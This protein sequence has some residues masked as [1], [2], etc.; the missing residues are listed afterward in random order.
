MMAATQ[1]PACSLVGKPNRTGRAPFGRAQDA[2]GRF[3]DDAELAFRADDQAEDVE[4]GRIEMRAAD[5]HTA[6]VQHDQRDAEHVVGGDAVFQAMRA[7]RIHADIAADRAGELR[8]RVGRVEEALGHDLAGDG[9]IGDAGLH[10]R[11]AVGIV[12]LEDAVHLGDAD[13]DRVLLRDRAAGQRGA[14]PARIVVLRH[15]WYFFFTTFTMA[16]Q[17]LISFSV[18]E[19]MVKIDDKS[20][21]S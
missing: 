18:F 3:R 14:G 12:D 13:D 11:D 20:G 9:E 5:L 2:H 10:L 1:E 21:R 8:G 17:M 4:P 6:A 16:Q 15:D 7:A 19:T